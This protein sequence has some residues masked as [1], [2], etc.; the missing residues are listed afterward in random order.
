MKPLV[1]VLI[2][3][4]H[5]EQWIADTLRSAIAQTW[6]SKEIIVVDDGSRDQTLAIARQFE[7]DVVRVVTQKNQGAA[8]ARNTAFSLSKGDYIQ[9]LDA[10]DLLAPDKIARQVNV[11]EQVHNKRVL[12][13]GPWGSF[14]YRPHRAE[15]IPTPLWRDLSPTEWLVYKMGQNLQMQTGTWLV[16][17]ELTE[18]AGPWDTRLLVDDDGEYFCRILLASEGTRF[19]PQANVYYRATANSL[20]YIGHASNKLD[21]QWISMRAH[22]GYLR[23]LEDSQRT[24][25][26]CVKYLQDWLTFFYPERLDIVAQARAMAKELGGQLEVPPLSWKY[27]WIDAVFGRTWA[28]RG[29][30]FLPR[31]KWSIVRSWDKAL[32]HLESRKAVNGLPGL[33]S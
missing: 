24:R 16:S 2:P 17:R 27:S 28:K 19:V 30:V 5:A 22:V 8:A 20:S 7:S 21:A 29:Q 1:S 14:M 10:D 18:A 31:L 32:L 9:W 13:S 4:Y 12:L 3:A 33:L 6:E 25:E 26:V 23:S 15:F 11:A